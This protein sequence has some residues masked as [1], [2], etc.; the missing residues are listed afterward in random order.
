MLQERFLPL[1]KIKGNI[2]SVLRA[3]TRLLHSLESALPISFALLRL[4]KGLILRINYSKY[5]LGSLSLTQWERIPNYFNSEIRHLLK[6]IHPLR[7]SRKSPTINRNNKLCL[8]EERVSRL[9]QSSKHSMKLTL[10]LH[11]LA[12]QK[13]STAIL[14]V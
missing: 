2:F 10:F 4:C 11:F 9:I 14:N 7:R 3:V 8:L 1:R 12:T 13:S 5:A 6:K